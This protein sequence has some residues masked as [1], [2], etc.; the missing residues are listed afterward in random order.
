MFRGV[1][2]AP[3]ITSR[4]RESIPPPSG[5]H[6]ALFGRLNY[7]EAVLDLLSQAEV[8]STAASKPWVIFASV[9]FTGV[10]IRGRERSNLVRELDGSGHHRI[11]LVGQRDEPCIG[12]PR[13]PG[14]GDFIAG[15]FRR[16]TLPIAF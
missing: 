13:R 3:S 15:D 16:K 11:S 6:R 4:P 12:V 5:L 2:H 7:S 1:A 9:P 10:L 14:R 8:A